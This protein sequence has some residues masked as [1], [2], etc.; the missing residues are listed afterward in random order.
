MQKDLTI[1][2]IGA[3]N[4]SNAI[5]TGLV[6]KGMDPK[7][8]MASNPSQPKLDELSKRLGILHTNDN[9]I[10]ID[11]ADIVML[12]VKPQLMQEV[13][14][15]FVNKKPERVFVSIAAGLSIERLQSFLPD[16]S[17]VIRVMPN[18]PSAIGL[19]MSGIYG[20]DNADDKDI[21]NVSNIMNSVGKSLVVDD[22]S[23]IDAVIAAAGSS[24]AYFFLIAESM[25]KAAMGMGLSADAAR[26]LVEQ[27]MLGSATLMQHKQDLSLE[28]LRSQ[29]TSKGGTT[30]EAIKSLQSDDIEQILSKAMHAAVKRAQEMTTQF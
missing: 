2:F 21:K 12:S 16:D 11:F 1:S 27:A 5:I 4:M 13:C 26:T 10:A 25:Q 24:P 3:G 9:Q 20:A 19:G 6:Q 28:E 7:C 15:P 30:A 18:T 29:V 23:H 22:E 17:K 14:Q 8:I